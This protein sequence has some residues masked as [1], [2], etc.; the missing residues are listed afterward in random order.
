M[1][2]YF[3]RGII[4]DL[5]NRYFYEQSAEWIASDLSNE[6]VMCHLMVLRLIY[7]LKLHSKRVLTAISNGLLSVCFRRCIYTRLYGL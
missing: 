4:Q 3:A 6:T 7:V 1:I 2:L 5:T